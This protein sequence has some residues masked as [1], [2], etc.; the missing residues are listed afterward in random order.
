[1]SKRK[2][3][4]RGFTLVEL[5]VVI[6]IIAILIGIL[7]PALRLAKDKANALKCQTNMRQ[8][9]QAMIYFANEHH[10]RM[11]G[12]DADRGRVEE[13]ERDWIYG[14]PKGWSDAKAWAECPAGGTI[15][16]YVRNKTL[17]RCPS[18]VATYGLTSPT[19]GPRAGSNDRFDFG[20][21]TGWA[22]AKMSKMKLNGQFVNYTKAKGAVGRVEPLPP[23]V[24][25]EEDSYTMNGT[26]TESG[27]SNQDAMDHHHGGGSYYAAIDGS[28]HFRIEPKF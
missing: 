26:N 6:G 4:S 17:F 20:Y 25:C 13:D 19:G 24:V 14:P 8:M 3:S 7:L 27:H 12:R 10:D 23:P 11:P 2:H 16:K 9:I 18:K 1:M 22:G 21:F 15:Y 28:V 5:L